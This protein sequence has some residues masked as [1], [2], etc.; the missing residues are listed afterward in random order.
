MIKPDVTNRG[1]V[2]KVISEMEEKGFRVMEMKMLNLS[3][4]LA[5]K[6]YEEH[7]GKGFFAEMIEM[8]TSGPVVAMV[9]ESDDHDD[10]QLGYREILG[11]TNP[12]E[13]D[14]GTIRSLYGLSIGQNSVHGSDSKESAIREIEFFFGK[15]A[16]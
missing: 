5:S 3:K 6:F 16:I 1:L 14:E 2:G 9:V 8:I 11:H 12:E 13:A 7:N 4:E 15:N 10:V